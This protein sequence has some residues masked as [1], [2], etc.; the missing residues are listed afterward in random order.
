MMGAGG[1]YSVEGKSSATGEQDVSTGGSR[2][3]QGYRNSIIN[4]FASGGS[5]LTAS[6]GMGFDNKTMM[7]MGAAAIAVWYLMKRK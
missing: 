3:G 2:A 7:I 5:S 1:S 4:N 6:T